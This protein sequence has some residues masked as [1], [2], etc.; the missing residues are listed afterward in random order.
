M[1]RTFI[2][3]AFLVSTLLFASDKPYQISLG[4]TGGS[5]QETKSCAGWNITADF[6]LTNVFK[7]RV[8]GGVTQYNEDESCVSCSGEEDPEK[9]DIYQH[10]SGINLNLGVS[11]YLNL[12]KSFKLISSF[13]TGIH[14]ISS[15]ES[16]NGEEMSNLLDPDKDYPSSKNFYLNGKIDTSINYYFSDY[17]S[18]YLSG[19]MFL[20]YLL[21]T[22]EPKEL[23]RES[24]KDF[25]L[26]YFIGIGVSVSF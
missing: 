26:G 7:L 9:I 20:N 12:S 11:H 16:T 3:L 18:M 17:F 25:D 23:V 24:I 10:E 4:L 19:G 13:T 21:S 8:S 5:T 6:P 14:L 15:N 22:E 2:L 1:K